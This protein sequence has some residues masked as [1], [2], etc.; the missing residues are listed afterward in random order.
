MWSGV[1][2]AGIALGSV[3]SGVLVEHFWWGSVFLVNLPAMVLLLVLGPSC[4]RSPRTRRPAAS[5]C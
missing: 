2:A 1:M 3:M 5:T 4:S